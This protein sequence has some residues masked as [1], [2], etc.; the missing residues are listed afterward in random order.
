MCS[1]SIWKAIKE[2][3]GKE[4]KTFQVKFDRTISFC[5]DG[6][7][8]RKC[9]V[10]VRPFYDKTEEKLKKNEQRSKKSKR[11]EQSRKEKKS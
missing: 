9:N 5:N 10:C 7:I 11:I 6:N 2:G 4:R 8:E 1:S 3:N